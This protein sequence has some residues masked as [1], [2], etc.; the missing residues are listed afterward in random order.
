LRGYRG[1]GPVLV[2]NA[3]SNQQQNDVYGEVIL[4]AADFVAR[5]G[6]IDD[7]EKELVA[8]FARMACEVWREPDNG[9]WEIRSAPRHNTYS[10]LMCWAA[11]DRTLQIHATHPLPIDIAVV[12]RERDAIRADIEAHGWDEK[13]QS[14]VG[15]YGGTEPDASLLLMPRLGFI[16]ARA[17]RMLATTDRIARELSVDG[18]LYRFPPGKRY[19]GVAGGEH[20]FAICS[21]WFVDCLAR[22]GRVDEARAIYEKL[23]ALR[24]A[25]GLYAEEFE[26]KTGRPVG[27]F[28]QAFSHVGSITAALSLRA[29][30]GHG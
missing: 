17:P 5:G 24:N 3:A 8:N 27:N 25:A 21:F 19:D 18:L 9:I 1:I 29:A 2:G 16:D 26:V 10:K 20:L 28:P 6:K 14:Y 15:Y 13:T 23:L 7:R 22:Q 12:T 30:Q 11:L 4:T